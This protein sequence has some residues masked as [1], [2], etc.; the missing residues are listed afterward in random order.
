M[1]FNR[2]FHLGGFGTKNE[3]PPLVLATSAFF[4][5]D[6]QC[7]NA[8]FF[9]WRHLCSESG[10]FETFFAFATHFERESFFFVFR[11]VRLSKIL[12]GALVLSTFANFCAD[13]CSENAYFLFL[14]HLCGESASF[15]VW[16]VWALPSNFHFS[17]FLRRIFDAVQV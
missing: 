2:F 5:S 10:R 3:A 17:L 8:I 4:L 7:G 13:V 9:R 15:G 14:R 16:L 12:T 1:F 6:V 11:H